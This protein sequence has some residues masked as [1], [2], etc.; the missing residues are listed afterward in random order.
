MLTQLAMASWEVIGR[1]SLMALTNTCSAAEYRRM[2]REKQAAA[3]A[4]ATKF[5]TSG[6]AVSMAAMLAPWHVRATANVRRL[7]KR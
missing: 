4:S 7:R 6:G 5:A 1:R 3:L 2:V